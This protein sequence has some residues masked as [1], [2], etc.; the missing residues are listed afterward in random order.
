M[1]MNNSHYFQNLVTFLIWV[2]GAECVTVLVQIY[3]VYL[4]YYHK[5]RM[6]RSTTIKMKTNWKSKFL[7]ISNSTNTLSKVLDD[8]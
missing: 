4:S 3:F 6:T 2:K 8:K 1:T 5:F 7:H